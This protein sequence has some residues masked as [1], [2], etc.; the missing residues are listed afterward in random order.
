MG[1]SGER[2]LVEPHRGRVSVAAL[3]ALE[4][5]EAIRAAGAAAG[6]GGRLASRAELAA[7][8]GVTESAVRNALTVLEVLGMV[9]V[10]SGSGTYVVD[11]GASHGTCPVCG[12]VSAQDGRRHAG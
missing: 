12:A 3:A 7:Q 9:E 11:V 5:A 8:L 1:A 2:L 6:A 4:L 10:R